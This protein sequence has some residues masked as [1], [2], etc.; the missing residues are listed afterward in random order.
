MSSHDVVGLLYV[1]IAIMFCLYSHIVPFC[2]TVYVI[3][4]IKCHILWYL[5]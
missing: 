3:A 5:K 1:L 2:L 4:L